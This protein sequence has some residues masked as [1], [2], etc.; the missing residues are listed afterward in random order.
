[1]KI[2]TSSLLCIAFNL[3]FP[4]YSM[5]KDD[6]S[7]ELTTMNSQKDFETVPL[8][9]EMK[10]DLNDVFSAEDVF[11][12]VKI[13]IKDTLGITLDKKLSSNVSALMLN[14]AKAKI[15]S[16]CKKAA[17]AFLVLNYMSLDCEKLGIIAER[18]VNEGVLNAM[19]WDEAFAETEWGKQVVSL[20][21]KN[22]Y[23]IGEALKTGPNT[24]L[25]PPAE[26]SHLTEF[27][28]RNQSLQSLHDF[29]CQ[30]LPVLE[31][32]DVAYNKLRRTFLSILLKCKNLSDINLS[33][34][35]IQDVSE[36]ALLSLRKGLKLNLE[37]NQI[38][39]FP[40]V[41]L[42]W[43]EGCLINLDGNPLTE[44]A[45]AKIAR[46]VKYKRYHAVLGNLRP[47][48]TIPAIPAVACGLTLLI[49]GAVF[50]ERTDRYYLNVYDSYLNCFLAYFLTNAIACRSPLNWPYLRSSLKSMSRNM[51][52]SGEW[53]EAF[54]RRFIEVADAFVGALK[55]QGADIIVGDQGPDA[56]FCEN[57]ITKYRIENFFHDDLK[58]GSFKKCLN[59]PS[60]CSNGVAL[61]SKQVPSSSIDT[62][63]LCY[64]Q[65]RPFTINTPLNLSWPLSNLSVEIPFTKQETMPFYTFFVAP[66]GVILGMILLARLLY[67]FAPTTC[68][69]YEPCTIKFAQQK[70]DAE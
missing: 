51:V 59:N 62:N 54:Q 12:Q 56:D 17:R 58:F 57:V 43:K 36:R 9:K 4:I 24:N 49:L 8:M 44:T 28:L 52:A 48:I 68:R 13:G 53:T 55:A 25:Y 21:E 60:H 19:K 1:M 6:N 39:H 42:Q 18:Y 67:V 37:S 65:N 40:D 23:S 50:Q 69:I 38:E 61:Y 34:N 47:F 22:A 26:F 70:K 45:Q 46:A 27:S 35:Q 5:E 10:E 32:F 7:F 14:P 15:S 30:Q 29:P 11:K 41:L 63:S 31:K 2:V 66:A 16:D 33:F 64:L 20:L 3:I